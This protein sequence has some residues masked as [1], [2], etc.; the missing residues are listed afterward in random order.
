MSDDIVER[1][2]AQFDDSVS[3]DAKAEIIRLR[4]QLA[5]ANERATKYALYVVA[6]KDAH[7]SILD[8]EKKR[9]RALRAKLD[10]AVKALGFY[11]E[12][13]ENSVDQEWTS[14]T[15]SEGSI[16]PLEP[17][18]ELVEDGGTRARTA[19]TAIKEGE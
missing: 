17:T 15:H 1:L 16:G 3:R 8:E 18:R 10:V 6:S 11:E 4:G 5:E 13:W 19:L 7:F 14:S 2:S 12:Q 9:A